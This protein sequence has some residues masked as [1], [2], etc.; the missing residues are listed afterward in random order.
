MRRQGVAVDHVPGSEG[1][2]NFV[3]AVD[4]TI[5]EFSTNRKLLEQSVQATSLKLKQ[6]YA[7]LKAE[8]SLRLTQAKLHQQ[9]LENL[10]EERTT[11]LRNAQL[12][13]EKI[14]KQL[15]YDATHDDLT[16]LA[17]RNQLMRE[18]NGCVAKLDTDF[19][20]SFFFIDFDR[21]KQINDKFGHLMGDKVLVQMAQHLSTL[22]SDTICFAR[23]G[24]DEFVMLM[25][26][27]DECEAF[28]LAQK[29]NQAFA[30]PLRMSDVEIPV[31]ASVGIVLA[32]ASY[33][34]ADEVVRDADIAM[35]RAKAMGNCYQL[36]DE[37][38]RTQHLDKIELEGELTIAVREQQFRV[39]FE[40]I[41]DI[42][43]SAIFSVES[44]VRWMHPEKGMISPN[45]FIP[46]A[47]EL[48][49]II[50]IDRIVF[51]KTCQ[52]FHQWREKGII[53][54]N[55]KF[56][57][58]LSC[59]QLQRSDIIPFLLSTVDGLDIGPHDIVLEITESYL[60]ADSGL[61][62]K[63]LNE[64]NQLGFSIFVDDFG[65]GY[66]SLSYLAKYPIHGIKIDRSFVRDLEKSVESKELI[67]SIIAM[68]DALK[69]KVVTEGVETVEQL[70]VMTELGCRY[71]QGFLFTRPMTSTQA[72]TFFVDS[73]YREWLNQTPVD[74]GGA[75]I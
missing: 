72:Q 39:A 25:A 66:S 40:P 27:L 48:G 9:E 14:N 57:V 64:M 68:A 29:I 2:M 51:K 70:Q 26:S 41:V 56:N 58:N 30:R 60:L 52:Q 63:N 37:E 36:F 46:L 38:M 24:G 31:A 3:L 11:E 8:S 75:S 28:E 33:Q 34:S 67:R 50:E 13:L 54:P 12:R 69:L 18:L 1:W 10:V 62:M 45:T 71:I 53:S 74:H 17:N 55:Q 5:K 6:A 32:D 19:R 16:G 42:H 22:V 35:Y 49:L 20:F 7:D 73:P 4:Q 61:V 23:L 47:E 21:F 65:T 59:A 15:E 44:L 43:G